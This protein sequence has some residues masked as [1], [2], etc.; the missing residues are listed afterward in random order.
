MTHSSLALSVI[1]QLNGS[2]LCSHR[3][4]HAMTIILLGEFGR[5]VA[6]VQPHGKD[7]AHPHRERLKWRF[8]PRCSCA[9]RIGQRHRS[10][11]RLKSSYVLRLALVIEELQAAAF[12]LLRRMTLTNDFDGDLRLSAEIQMAVSE[13]GLPHLCLA[14]QSN[15]STAGRFGCYFSSRLRRAA[16]EE[17]CSDKVD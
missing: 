16:R 14:R 11:A 2:L 12:V 8:S 1:S 4:I 3:R 5:E 6:T 7:R 17:G 9:P 10:S 15:P 13:R